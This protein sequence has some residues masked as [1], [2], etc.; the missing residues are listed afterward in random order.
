[1][2]HVSL[3]VNR[4]L[5]QLLPGVDARFAAVL[6]S[7]G[8]TAKG[9]Q[10]SWILKNTEAAI[11]LVH[12]WNSIYSEQSPSQPLLHAYD[13][14]CLYTNIDTD[15]MKTQNM[16]LIGKVFAA[17]S[18]HVGIKVW[19]KAP[20]VWL[21]A[22]QIPTDDA[23][24][25]GTG[26]GGEYFIFDLDTIDTFISHLLDNMYVTFGDNLLRQIIG[27]PMGTN[28]ASLLANFYLAMY[29]LAFLENLACIILNPATPEPKRSQVRNI[30]SG[31]L[32]TGRF[33]DDLLTINNPYIGYLLYTS[34]TL[35]Y[36][37]VKGIYPD[38]LLLSLAHTGMSIPYMD[39]TIGPEAGSKPR[40]T[41]VPYDKRLH[42][43]M[44]SVFIIKYPH[45]SSNISRTA[46]YKLSPANSTDFAESSYPDAAL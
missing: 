3:L 39:I 14:K 41:T 10:R 5:T 36:P 17:H 28:C 8:I 2:K 32:M 16:R 4:L 27:T 13:F 25:R 23:H 20:A 6:Q 15:D 12:A 46:K 42:P 18:G 44:S 19:Q 26:H 34:Q 7:V 38:T 30:M 21:K 35:F 9:A 24:R 45:M 40:L 33:I 29:E 37:D 22:H 43:P 1:M 11:P 31:F